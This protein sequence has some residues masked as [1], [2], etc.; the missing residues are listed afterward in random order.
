MSAIATSSE[1]CS[2]ARR[3]LRGHIEQVGFFLADFDERDSGFLLRE[4]RALGADAFDHQSEYHVSLRDEMRPEIIGWAARAGACLVEVHSHGERGT[5]CF[6]PSDV[7]GFDQWVPH[8]RWRLKKRPYAAVVTAGA[9]FDALAWIGM[10]A[11]PVQVERLEVAGSSCPTSGLTLPRY[12]QL[13][14]RR[15]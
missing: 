10:G 1:I 11:D 3:H 5:P 6:S 4:W 9:R 13:R 8:V 14:R 15:P 12:E 7:F 2:A